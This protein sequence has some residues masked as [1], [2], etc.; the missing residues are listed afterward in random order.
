MPLTQKDA[1]EL[2]K[3]RH[4]AWVEHQR[5]WRWLQDSL[6]GGD[7][8]RHADYF[9]DPLL[10]PRPAAPWYAYGFDP[11]TG[12][13]YPIAYNQ[14]VMRNLIPH[15]SEMS[16]QGRDLYTMR[17]HRTPVPALVGRVVRRYLARIFARDVAR[18]G[19]APLSAWWEDVDGCGTPVDK[20]MRKTVAPLLLA[21]GQLDLVFGH[22][23][24]PE[25][26]DVR[27][28]ADQVKLG[29]DRCVVRPILPENLVWWRLDRA[30]RYAEA[31]VFERHDDWEAEGEGGGPRFR[32]WTAEASDVY[33][34]EGDHVD[35]ESFDHPFGRV[36]IVRVFDER[37]HRDAHVGQSRL[38]VVAELQQSVYNRSSELILADVQQSHSVLQG[39]E[40]YCQSDAKVPIGPGG[41][42]PK[43][44][45][46]DGTGYDGFD[47][48]DPPKGAQEACR[49]HLLD[50]RDEA[51]REAA[52][53]KPAGMVSGTTTG[54]SGVSKMADQTESN[55][56]LSEVAETLRD[57][58]RAIA[59]MALVVLS[60][61]DP[62]PGDLDAIDVQY[63]REFDLFTASDLAAALAD[64]QAIAA[65]AGVLPEAET[66]LLRRLITVALPGLDKERLRELHDEAAEVVAAKADERDRRSESSSVALDPAV[67][68]AVAVD[69]A[70]VDPPTESASLP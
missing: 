64:V 6:E 48:L 18:E 8:Y 69:A 56:V 14:V 27:T 70:E 62:A 17:L 3:R 46:T 35:D 49:Q 25:D 67:E 50:D 43:K 33:T 12:E 29:L 44:R 66:E 63:P 34:S 1:A 59:E 39:P 53:L 22:P 60:D 68:Q 61:G 10:R 11:A 28:R 32:H 13:G 41:I 58:E 42:L 31:L 45:R 7:R 65:D 15:L 4:P 5:R 23:E 16:I 40:E 51:D 21:L 55:D 2:V 19:P 38:E 52:L 37:K 24:T 9:A 30:G 20:W 26:A 57:A 47:F 54:Q 36:P